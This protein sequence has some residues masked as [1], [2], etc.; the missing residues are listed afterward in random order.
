MSDSDDLQEYW[1]D[2]NPG[3]PKPPPRKCCICGLG[4]E[5]YRRIR[6]KNESKGNYPEDGFVLIQAHTGLGNTWDQ[7]VCIWCHSFLY[8]YFR[9][10]LI[11]EVEEKV[12]NRICVEMSNEITELFKKYRTDLPQ[13]VTTV[14]KTISVG[15]KPMLG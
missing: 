14:F 5:G 2:L 15:G 6:E 12:R 13:D 4:E 3:P 8:S 1:Q 9:D 10:K 7:L 11:T